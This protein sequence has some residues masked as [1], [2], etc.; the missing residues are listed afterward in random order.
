MCESSDRG[1]SVIWR[2]TIIKETIY[3]TRFSTLRQECP[4]K[5]QNSS[6]DQYH[7]RIARFLTISRLATRSDVF[8]TTLFLLL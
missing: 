7:V 4:E 2:A 3:G 1:G 8:C 6:F 5:P